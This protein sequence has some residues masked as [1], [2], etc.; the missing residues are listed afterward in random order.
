MLISLLTEVGEVI[1]WR[2]KDCLVSLGL[3]VIPLCRGLIDPQIGQWMLHP[4]EEPI[5]LKEACRLH[6]IPMAVDGLSQVN[7][8]WDKMQTDLARQ[9]LIGPFR[10]QEMRL[11]PV[12][13]TMEHTGMLF[14]ARSLQQLT[15][16]IK[17]KMDIL[18]REACDL[19]GGAGRQVNLGSAQQMTAVLF[20]EL[21]LPR[22]QKRT[23]GGSRLSLTKDVLQELRTH[24][25]HF[26]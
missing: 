12:L 25:F 24:G 7:Q 1:C 18:Q 19:I 3:G 8:L 23:T 21:C 4:S 14:D 15:E 16:E 9:E 20:D 13:A 5:S 2:A 6:S 11:V 17:L 26:H 22:P 10:V